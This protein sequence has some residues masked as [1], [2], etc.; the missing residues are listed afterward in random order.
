MKFMSSFLFL[1]ATFV[2]CSENGA[3][4]TPTDVQGLT[5]RTFGH[6]KLFGGH[7]KGGG[8]GGIGGGK[9]GYGIGGGGDM[10]GDEHQA[11]PIYNA[12]QP[13]PVYNPQVYNVPQPIP[14]FN[15]APVSPPVPI[16]TNPAPV[17]QQP[18]P[19]YGGAS[20]GY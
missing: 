6:G 2:T 11:A 9:G 16:L 17:Y 20:S 19:I 10:D 5:A 12:P 15:P 4:A 18:A 3:I 7:R 8:Y 1:V 13:A 14:V